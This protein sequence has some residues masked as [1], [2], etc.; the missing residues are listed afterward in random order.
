MDIIKRFLNWFWYNDSYI[1]LVL[2]GS[3]AAYTIL[4]FISFIVR[5]LYSDKTPSD[6]IR[7][8][9]EILFSV[10]G[11]PFI[12]YRFYD[13][14]KELRK[15]Y[16]FRKNQKRANRILKEWGPILDRRKTELQKQD[17][18]RRID[19]VDETFE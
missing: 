8:F 18:F 3:I 19:L 10:I 12:C 13:K 9:S 11:L 2:R 7:L 16:L 14:F 1:P 6:P 17:N 4:G 15:E 5:L